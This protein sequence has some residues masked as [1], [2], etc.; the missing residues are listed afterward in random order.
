MTI[1]LRYTYGSIIP[2]PEYPNS[3]AEALDMLEAAHAD[4]GTCPKCYDMTYGR[5]SNDENY[6][7]VAVFSI[8]GV[9]NEI[10]D[11]SN[12]SAIQSLAEA[13]APDV[14]VHNGVGTT[15]CIDPATVDIDILADII[16]TAEAF[17]DYPLLDE[18]DYSE[19]EFIAFQ[20]CFTWESRMIDHE[21]TL[22]SDHPA[23]RAATEYAME[24][25]YGYSDPGHIDRNDVI[26]SWRAAGVEL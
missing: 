17:E 26:E 5:P 14:Y 25:Y 9:C 1:S 3:A 20:E 22:D 11:D 7:R 13:W 23:W 12:E 6:R 4:F 24:Y 2:T 10:L 15:V 16:R 18:S 19:R 8:G 21:P